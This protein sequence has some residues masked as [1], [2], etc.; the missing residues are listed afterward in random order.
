MFVDLVG[1][2]QA[3]VFP[4]PSLAV[5]A[6]LGQ[7]RAASPAGSERRLS[8]RQT[9]NVFKYK[10]I[11]VKKTSNYTQ[12]ILN[13][14]VGSQKNTLTLKVRCAGAGAVSRH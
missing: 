13:T 12:V 8:V 2:S 6:K 3:F 7:A 11:L 9:E 4:V 10:N 14:C 5:S 1:A